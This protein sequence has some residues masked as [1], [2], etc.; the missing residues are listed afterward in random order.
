M[1]EVVFHELTGFR[2]IEPDFD[3]QKVLEEMFGIKRFEERVPPKSDVVSKEPDELDCR[4]IG[5]LKGKKVIFT[6]SE[7]DEYILYWPTP[8]R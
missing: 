2:L 6:E 1:V 3:G 4:L 5:F 7:L 8:F